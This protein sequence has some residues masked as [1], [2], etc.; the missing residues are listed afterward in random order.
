MAAVLEY[1]TAELL[2]LAGNATKAAKK[3]RITPR[4]IFLAVKEDDELDK[5]LS[6]AMISTGGVKQHIDPFLDQRKGK[7]NQD[8]QKTSAA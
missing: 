8:V 1:L 7:K 6:K 2:E 4:A 3:Q 5:L